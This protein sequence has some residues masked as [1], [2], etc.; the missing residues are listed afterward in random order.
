MFFVC[1][2]GN[3]RPIHSWRKFWNIL[4]MSLWATVFLSFKKF[5]FRRLLKKV[6]NRTLPLVPVVT[7]KE[8]DHTWRVSSAAKSIH[9]QP[10][11][12]LDVA[13]SICNFAGNLS[14]ALL[15]IVTQ[16]VVINP[17]RRF[18]TTFRSH[19]HHH[20]LRNNPEKRRSHLH[21]CGSPK[22]YLVFIVLFQLSPWW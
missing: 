2:T 18:G 5:K 15:W 3:G 9:S 22:S 8:Q 12:P 7:F 20:T 10:S 4:T 17:Y 1:L 13:F 19:L 14:S 11:P 16:P 6:Q 21:R